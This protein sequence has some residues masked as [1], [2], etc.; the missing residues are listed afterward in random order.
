M[1]TRSIATL[2]R[3]AAGE[4]LTCD[5]AAGGFSRSDGGGGVAVVR[6]YNMTTASG[7]RADGPK[8]LRVTIVRE[9]ERERD[10]RV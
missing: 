1:R 2:G 6:A 8:I 3:R 9:R 5:V 4:T 7:T 10:W